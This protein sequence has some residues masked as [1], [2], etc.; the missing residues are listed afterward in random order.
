MSE[1]AGN[2]ANP[3]PTGNAPAPENVLSRR[4][5][6]RA[7]ALGDMGLS[8]GG[9]TLT[10]QRERDGG[11]QGDAVETLRV[12]GSRGSVET[13]R[14]EA[15]ASLTHFDRGRVSTPALRTASPAVRDCGRGP[16]RRDCHRGELDDP[17][18]PIMHLPLL[19]LGVLLPVDIEVGDRIVLCPLEKNG[20]G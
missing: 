2:P 7:G 8:A 18:F 1:R 9:G 6:V 10:V 17:P 19:P 11:P 4:Q 15:M 20:G 16:P 14:F 5:F 13:S 3:S 12:M